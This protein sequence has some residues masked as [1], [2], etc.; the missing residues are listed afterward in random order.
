MA[1]LDVLPLDQAKKHVN[2][3]L[4]ITTDDAEMTAFIEAAVERVDRHL[5]TEAERETG[6]S[7]TAAGEPVTP[8]R[9]LAVM[10][11][12]AEYWRTQRPRGARSG[13]AAVSVAAVEA[14]SGPAGVASLTSRLTELL[15]PAAESS[16]GTAA[17][18][19]FPAAL[20]W[21][22]PALPAGRQW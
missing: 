9:R 12:F 15:G 17:V 5:W 19:S 20:P 2:T 22:D 10:V 7:L 4:A 16:S 21:P 11:V 14:D 8:S 13:G 3:E 18:G 6:R 1:A